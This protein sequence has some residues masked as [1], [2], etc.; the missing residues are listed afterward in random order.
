MTLPYDYARCGLPCYLAT[1]CRR[2][3]AGR[4]G[5]QAIALFEGGNDCSGYIERFPSSVRDVAPVTQ[6]GGE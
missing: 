6:E 5:Y 1:F 4:P 2:T 3:D